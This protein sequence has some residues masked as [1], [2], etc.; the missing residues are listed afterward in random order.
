[1]LELFF[2]EMSIQRLMTSVKAEGF[3]GYPRVYPKQGSAH[4][5]EHSVVKWRLGH[6]PWTDR[7]WDAEDSTT[8]DRL[9]KG[10]AGQSEG[11]GGSEPLEGF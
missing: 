4:F 10:S 3:W 6:G 1:M 11:R 5:H 7:S 9:I 2:P 8:A